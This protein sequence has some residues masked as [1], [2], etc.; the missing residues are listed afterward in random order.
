MAYGYLVQGDNPI[1][2]NFTVDR[3][4][5]SNLEGATVIVN[6][7]KGNY[8][9]Q[10]QAVILDPTKKEC[11]FELS[12]EDLS[13]SGKYSYQ[14]VVSFTDGR[15]YSGR[16]DSLT[17]TGK[18]T[19]GS[20]PPTD[21]PTIGS[22]ILTYET[23]SHLQAAYPSGTTQPVWITSANSWYYWEGTV[24]EPT[25]DTTAPNEVTNLV[26][27]PSQTSVSLSW[28]GSTSSDVASYEV[29]RGS[30]LVTTITGTSHNVTGLTVETLY[31]FTIKAKDS[32]GNISSGV[33]VSSTTLAED[34]T[35]PTDTTPPVL[36]I[37]PATTFT[38]TQ[39]VTMSTNE[40]AT[41]WYTLDDSD[42]KTSGTRVQYT[43]PL[44]LTATDTVKA[45]AVD[46]ANNQSAVQTVTY[47]KEIPLPP[48]DPVKGNFALDFTK[49][50]SLDRHVSL[51]SSTFNET[52]YTKIA[53]VYTANM[54]TTGNFNILS[55]TNSVLWVSNGVIGGGQGTSY[56]NST[57]VTI[58]P[59][60]WYHIAMVF[61]GTT[62]KYY[63]DGFEKFSGTPHQVSISEQT[64][65]QIGGYKTNF[66]WG[67]YIAGTWIYN[68]ALTAQEITNHDNGTV[69]RTGLTGEY[70]FEDQNT[71]DTSGLSN[72]GTPS[73]NTSFVN[74]SSI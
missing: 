74:V 30:I 65:L 48:A 22:G 12:S 11:E 61:D 6:V 72:N 16:T 50:T 46:S 29:W 64:D 63:V 19:G 55:S 41:I 54:T 21:P 44:T 4:E 68:R 20:T 27:T 56:G 3:A 33:S 73:A 37:T 53:Y 13:I 15:L 34:V 17:V 66:Q 2:I 5:V 7:K 23:L 39:T 9:F 69:V 51:P 35:P 40:T 18:L 36:T 42:P 58:T 57:G 14:Y 70:L 71:N 28:T 49:V 8:L 60:T 26:A 59:N 25:P 31:N 62:L 52:A 47:T 38:D 67:G 43:S 1:T 45:Y 32:S 24:T 10:K